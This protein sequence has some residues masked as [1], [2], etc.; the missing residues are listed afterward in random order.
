M[1]FNKEKINYRLLTISLSAIGMFGVFTF[2]FAAATSTF[3]QTINPGT[4]S[5]DIVD[6]SYVTVGSPSISMTAATVNFSCQTV[7]GTFGTATEQI[8]IKNPDA[9]DSG[10]TV[11][12]AGSAPTAVWDGG[13]VD[14]DFNDS[15]GSGCTDGADS[16]SLGGQMTVDP[17][18][19]TLA[20][21]QCLTC[22]VTGVSKGS[23]DAFVEG[24]KDSITILSAAAGSDDIGDWKL[25]G[26]SISQKI[27][28]EIPVGS[29]S[30]GLTLS[31]IAL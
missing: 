22:G 1:P 7:T 27:P 16:D 25:T 31:I 10:W 17:S 14:Y 6:A 21:G 19:G 26:V 29:Y 9:A 28:A 2:I 5:V 3:N 13:A 12:L 8:Y 20:K 4:L 23:S 11:S 24:T 18:G 30:V 15:T